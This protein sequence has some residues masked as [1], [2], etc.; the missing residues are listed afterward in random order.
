MAE[1]A[2]GEPAMRYVC[3]KCGETYTVRPVSGTCL[4][5]NATLVVEPES[6]EAE[7]RRDR[8]GIPSPKRRLKG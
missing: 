2:D 4:S 7:E 8:E 6:H 3:P 5:C 1:N